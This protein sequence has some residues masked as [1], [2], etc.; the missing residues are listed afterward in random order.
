MSL[1]ALIQSQ[2]FATL[3]AALGT[4]PG[5]AVGRVVEARLLSL[6]ADGSAVARVGDTDIALVLAGPQA[7]QAAL[8]PGATLLLRIDAAQEPG[9]GLRATL[10]EARAPTPD[11]PASPASRSVQAPSL[12]PPAGQPLPPTPDAAGQPRPAV[13]TA[14]SQP[15]PASLATPGQ[16]APAGA[17][18]PA[19]LLAGPLLGPALARQDSLAPLFANLRG[20]AEGSVALV[21]PKPLLAAVERVL[22]QALPAE[23]GAV[24]GR[25]LSRAVSRSGLFHEAAQAR[26]GAPAQGDLKAA[27]QGLRDLLQPLVGER[28]GR[29]ASAAPPD[30]AAPEAASP[31]QP[32][33]PAPPR[34]DGPLTPQPIVEAS[35]SPA[36][37]P[38]FVASALFEQTE[39]ALDRIVLSQF[40]SLPPEAGRADPSQTQRWLAELPLA[41]QAG[42]AVLPLR[43]EREPPR[44]EAD[45][46][47][48][49]LWR[50]RF[51]LDVE[52]IGPLQG[53]VTLQGRSV[54]VSLWAERE[55]TSL[56]LRDAA[57]G[58]EA[59]LAGA[60]FERGGIDIRTGRP[61]VAQATAGQ[62]LDR[63]S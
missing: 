61:A 27:L 14:A 4:S 58:L 1:A 13:P 7:R 57:P 5:L 22:S 25:D 15:G 2:N 8:Q 9:T 45:G 26:T 11:T 20:L 46:V 32:A 36:E 17:A 30:G 44:R 19:R 28:A 60:D 21:L 37:R 51:A 16:T 34:R 42:V 40:A 3:L 55:E 39:A 33:R 43:I 6:G 49:P 47:L 59:S 10:L 23:N 38:G 56:A 48:G 35:L 62:F 54:G 50:V 31:A 29:P 12:Q 41:F 52:P 53:V 24:S 63:L 18:A